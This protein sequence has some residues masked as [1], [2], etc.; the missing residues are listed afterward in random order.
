MPLRKK[1]PPQRRRLLPSLQANSRVLDAVLGTLAGLVSSSLFVLALFVGFC[2]LFGLAKLARPPGAAPIVKSLDE[3]LT[4][5]P[6]EYLSPD[7]PARPRRP[8]PHPGT[9]RGGRT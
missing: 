8:A 3:R 2:V 7:T 9:H 4:H 1:L 5:R 6:V